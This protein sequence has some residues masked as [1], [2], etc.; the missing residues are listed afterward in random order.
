MSDAFDIC[1]PISLTRD[2]RK[3]PLMAFPILISEQLG[4]HQ[5]P[6]PIVLEI[7][8]RWIGFAALDHR[9]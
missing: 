6:A 4:I 8:V 1:G 3:L 5:L 2:F 7:M 9:V